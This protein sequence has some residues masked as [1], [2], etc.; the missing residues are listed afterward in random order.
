MA[1]SIFLKYLR[2]LEEFRKNPHV[3]I[4]PKSSC[5]NFQSLVIF[6]NLIFIQK[7]IFFRFWP[8]QPS[9]APRWPAPP[10]RPPAP[11]LP[12]SAQAALAYFS[13]G[14]FSLTLCTPA[15]TPSLSHIT[16]NWGPHVSSIPFLTPTDR[17]RFSSSSPATLRRPASPSNAGRANTRPATI[18][19]PPLIPLLTSPPSSMALKP[20]TPPLLPLGHPSLAPPGTYKRA[21]RP[22]DPHRTSS[23]LFRAS[24]RPPPPSRRARATAVHCLWCDAS[25]PLLRHQ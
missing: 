4:P 7:G 20:L 17:C 22:P 15:E 1:Y 18:S 3:K 10:H 12:H 14:V 9:P 24:S 19:P 11:R 6:K 21:M 5:A 23:P 8:I 13:K 2:R 25:L 16:A